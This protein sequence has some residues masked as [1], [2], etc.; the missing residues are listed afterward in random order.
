MLSPL[1]NLLFTPVLSGFLTISTLLFFSE[2]IHL[3]NGIVVWI[4]EKLTTAWLWVM[5]LGNSPCMLVGFRTPSLVVLL[6]IAACALGIVLHK[7]TRS[8]YRSILLLSLLL[9]SAS[10][11]LKFCSAPAPIITEIPC[12]TGHV[13][14]IRTGGTTTLIDP[15]VIGKRISASS[16]VD[17]TLIPTIVQTTGSTTIDHVIALQ[18]GICT[19]DALERL[20][21]GTNVKH[22]Y[23]VAWDG[24]LSHAG[25]RSFFGLKRTAEH[26]NTRV[27]RIGTRPT[28]ISLAAHSCLTITPETE[29]ISYQ[30]CTYPA[31]RLAGQIDNQSFTIYSSKRGESAGQRDNQ[32]TVQTKGLYTMNKVVLVIAAEGYQSIEY[33][34]P[35]SILEN[36]GITVLTASDQPGTA[37]AHDGTTTTIDLTLEQIDVD[38][39]DALFFIGGPGAM[40]HLDNP[41]SHALAQQC[42]KKRKPF[43]AICISTRILANSGAIPGRRVT[44]WDGDGELEKTLKLAGVAYVR[45]DVVVDG[46]L[47]TAVGPNAAQAFGAKILNTINPR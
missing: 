4:L 42:A 25:W 23:L 37:T 2:L 43:G 12:N 5:E 20:C 22:L 39:V 28:T 10:T 17:Y 11:Y 1:G 41:T 27:V 33:S 30:E 32:D 3:P 14:L 38:D 18:P 19:F 24:S 8:L 7:K 21:N 45:S 15:G 35:K 44:G 26:H 36:S 46:S 31:L 40:E 13:T 6:G 47:I 9:A 34:V 16:W 29:R